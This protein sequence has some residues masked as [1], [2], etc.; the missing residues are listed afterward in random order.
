ME[1]VVGLDPAAVVNMEGVVGLDPSAV[2]NMEGVVGSDSV[3][4]EQLPSTPTIQ[5]GLDSTDCE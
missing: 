3:D 5:G 2:P 1:G 4:C